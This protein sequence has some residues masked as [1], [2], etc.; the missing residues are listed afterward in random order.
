[1]CSSDLSFYRLKQTDFDGKFEYSNAIH[2]FLVSE[3]SQYTMFPNPSPGTVHIVKSNES[4]EGVSIILYDMN[5][6]L[7][8]TDLQLMQNK[9]EL[10]INFDKSDADKNDFFVLKL[11][12]P[13]GIS[14]DK[15][16]VDKN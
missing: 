16:F 2:I 12:S 8:T 1:M 5:G 9:N 6:K 4:M 15:L 11:I 7:V 13:E 3:Q 10:T 14:S